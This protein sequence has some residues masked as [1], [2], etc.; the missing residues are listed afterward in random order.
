MWNRMGGMNSVEKP[1]SE[2]LKHFL[3]VLMSFTSPVR[4]AI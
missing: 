3:K 4:Q 1:Y 2:M